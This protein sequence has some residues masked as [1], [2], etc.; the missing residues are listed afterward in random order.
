MKTTKRILAALLALLLG[1][2]LLAPMATAE[3]SVVE[4]KLPAP[5]V[6][7][8]SGNN[9]KLEI[10]VEMTGE[11][12]P[13]ELA[14]AWYDCER[15]LSIDDDQPLPIATGP[16]LDT[17]VNFT[18]FTETSRIYSVVV[19]RILVDD[20]GEEHTYPAAVYT[21][22]VFVLPRFADLV[23]FTWETIL[24]LSGGSFPMAGISFILFSPFLLMLFLSISPIFLVFRAVSWFIGIAS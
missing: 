13:W 17:L 9:L 8:P 15:D 12:G 11:D 18:T 4:N 2:G 3:I 10:D 1:L 24:D 6:I 5:M 21:S 22:Q 23:S 7:V 20:D 19:S 16:K 14:Y